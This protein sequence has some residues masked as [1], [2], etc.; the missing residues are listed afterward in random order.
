MSAQDFKNNAARPSSLLS[1]EAINF[2]F[3]GL[4]SWL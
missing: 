1:L 4:V 3:V 2:I